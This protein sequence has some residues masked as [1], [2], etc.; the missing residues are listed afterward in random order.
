MSE[1]GKI[2]LLGVLLLRTRGVGRGVCV[3]GG[4]VGGGVGGGQVNAR[5]HDAQSLAKVI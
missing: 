4:G 2:V 1:I 3:G 5:Y